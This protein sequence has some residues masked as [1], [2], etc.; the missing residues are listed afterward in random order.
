MRAA[1]SRNSL[2]HEPFELRA[3][4]QIC[5]IPGSPIRQAAGM[6][7]PDRKPWREA[8]RGKTEWHSASVWRSTLVVAAVLLVTSIALWAFLGLTVLA[9]I[10]NSSAWALAFLAG[11]CFRQAVLDRGRLPWF[12]WLWLRDDPLLNRGEG[13]QPPERDA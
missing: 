9:V 8:L 13:D 7:S 4:R 2:Q 5:L 6:T 1:T 3:T 10:L 12:R 11:Y